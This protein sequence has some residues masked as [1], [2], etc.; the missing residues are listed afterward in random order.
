MYLIF[1]TF[2]E[3]K[4]RSAIRKHSFHC[5]CLHYFCRK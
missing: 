4:L 5:S 2:A 3:N 1:A